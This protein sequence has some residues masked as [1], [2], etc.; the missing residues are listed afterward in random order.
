MPPGLTPL[1]WG[2]HEAIITETL[3][4]GPRVFV[5]TRG[6]TG[7]TFGAFS[8]ELWEPMNGCHGGFG[9]LGFCA[10]GR[11]VAGRTFS[12]SVNLFVRCA[13][14]GVLCGTCLH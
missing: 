8:K 13:G 9:H 5:E 14:G 11:V 7:G 10:F 3:F 1:A 6:K 4:L 12:P 2:V